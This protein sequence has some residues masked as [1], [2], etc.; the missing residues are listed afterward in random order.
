M[1]GTASTPTPITGLS[2]FTDGVI[3]SYAAWANLSVASGAQTWSITQPSGFFINNIATTPLEF[4]GALSIKNGGYVVTA[5][6]GTSAGAIVGTSVTVATGDLLVAIALDSTN[7][8]TSGTLP[9]VNTT[10][11]TSINTYAQQNIV[12]WSGA[13]SA[14]QPTFTTTVGTDTYMVIQWIMSATAANTNSATIAWV[15]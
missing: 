14:I 2:N 4:S 10:G 7:A 9:T 3:S 8:G 6:P 15:T 5:A 11:S 12:Y 13:G 1:T